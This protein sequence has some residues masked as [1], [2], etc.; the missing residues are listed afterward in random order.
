MHRKFHDQAD[1]K[2]IVI[3]AQ[4]WGHID[5]PFGQP[6]PGRPISRSVVSRPQGVFG[7][8]SYRKCLKIWIQFEI[9][10]PV[11]PKAQPLYALCI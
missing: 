10:F 5:M 3:R 2:W 8:L 7:G 6:T 1:T 9:V 4:L 11:P